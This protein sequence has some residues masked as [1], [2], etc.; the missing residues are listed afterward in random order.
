MPWWLVWVVLVVLALAVL[1]WIGFRL[2][3]SF[4]ALLAE[5]RL[6]QGVLER[7]ETRLAELEEVAEATSA[8]A[9]EITASDE[10][11]AELREVRAGVSAVRRARKQARYDRVS[12]RWAGI[13]GGSTT[14]VSPSPEGEPRP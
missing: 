11:R 6:A 4:R 7:L 12:A 8:I 3:R 10:R 13:T 1:A 2:Y 9:P 14:T 5:V